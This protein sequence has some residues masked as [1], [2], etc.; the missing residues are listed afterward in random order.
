M[1][2]PFVEG[3]LRGV[4]AAQPLLGMR[5]ELIIEQQPALLGL[6]EEID[7]ALEDDRIV[8]LRKPRLARGEGKEK[9]LFAQDAPARSRLAQ[10]RE[11]KDAPELFLVEKSDLF[12]GKQPLLPH[13]GKLFPNGRAE[14]HMLQKGVIGGALFG[15]MPAPRALF[16]GR[17]LLPLGAPQL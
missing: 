11:R 8:R 15:R 3:D 17:E 16:F 12:F 14:A 2:P 10:G 13:A 4:V 9:G 1:R 5:R 7:G 6:S